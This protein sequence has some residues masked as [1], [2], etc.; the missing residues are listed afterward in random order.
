MGNLHD[1]CRNSV[2]F[3][4]VVASSFREDARCSIFASPSVTLNLLLF[5]FFSVFTHHISIVIYWLEVPRRVKL[6]LWLTP[7]NKW[8]HLASPLLRD[9]YQETLEDATSVTPNIMALFLPLELLKPCAPMKLN[10]NFN[11]A[12]SDIL[13]FTFFL[14]CLEICKIKNKCLSLGLYLSNAVMGL[15]LE[16]RSS[17]RPLSL[18]IVTFQNLRY[19]FP[20]WRPSIQYPL[21]GFFPPHILV[22]LE[23]HNF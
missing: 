16:V 1:L 6:K 18:Y 15:S 21:C 23:K 7:Y 13:H 11:L 14:N 12:M 5:H 19:I 17:Q 2:Y 9:A 10:L 8:P 3:W 20:L 22:P 4:H